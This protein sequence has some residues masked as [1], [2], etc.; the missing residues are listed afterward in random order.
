MG[1]LVSVALGAAEAT[2][3]TVGTAVLASTAG[4]AGWQALISKL[5]PT[6][7]QTAK[8]V[9]KLVRMAHSPVPSLSGKAEYA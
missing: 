7:K 4:A 6:V 8:R 9:R 3:S 5:A 2:T 1:T